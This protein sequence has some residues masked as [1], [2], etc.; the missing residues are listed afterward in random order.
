QLQQLL[1]M[2]GVELIAQLMAEDMVD[3]LWLTICPVIIGGKHAPTPCDG[4]GFRLPHV[5]QLQLLS[6]K[7]L[8]NEVFLHYRQPRP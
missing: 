2:G 8:G 3:E 7:T 5:P 6:A 1:V 4:P